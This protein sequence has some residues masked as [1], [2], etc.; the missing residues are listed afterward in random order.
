MRIVVLSDAH[1]YVA[2]IEKAIENSKP[3]VVIYCGDGVQKTED[4]SYLYP[5]IKFYF[6][7]GNCD[8]G[9]YPTEQEIKLGS[10]KVFFTHGHLYS[11]K[12]GYE[13]IINEAKVRGVDILLFGHTHIAFAEYIDGLYVMNPGSCVHPNMGRPSYGFI[14][15]VGS[16]IVTNIVEL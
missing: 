5:D 7:K 6:V 10:K 3:D 14:D 13:K 2:P 12:S 9:N 11:V 1:G 4:I 16:S 15:I 8:F